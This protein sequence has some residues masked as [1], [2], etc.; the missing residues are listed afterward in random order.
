MVK[1]RFALA[2]S[3]ATPGAPLPLMAMLALTAISP[4]LRRMVWPASDEE[5]T[6]VSP[7]TALSTA[8][9]SEPAPLSALFWTIQIVALGR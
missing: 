8:W 4:Q 1:M 9:R 6:I 7:L 2:P 5:K 3:T